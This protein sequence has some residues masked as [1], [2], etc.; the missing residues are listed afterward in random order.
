MVSSS[1]GPRAAG[2]AAAGTE[3]GTAEEKTWEGLWRARLRAVLI[4]LTRA[5][6]RTL[7]CL[8]AVAVVFWI[9]ARRLVLARIGF[10]ESYFLWTGWSLN[11]G[12]VPY[13]DFIEYKPVMIFVLNALGLRLFG[14]DYHHYRYAFAILSGS[15]FLF[16]SLALIR[17]GADALLTFCVVVAMASAL[18]AP[19]LHDLTIN[20]TETVGISFLVLGLA[21]LLWGG[22]HVDLAN[23]LGGAFLALAVMS[24]EPYGFISLTTW[25]ALGFFNRTDSGLPWRRYAVRTCAG[26]AIVALGILGFLLVTGALPYYVTAMRDYFAYTARIGCPKPTTLFDLATVAWRQMTRTLVTPAILGGLLPF[27]IAFAIGSRAR[28]GARIAVVLV[29]LAGVHAVSLGGCYWRHYFIMGL[30]GFLLWGALGAVALGRS[31]SRAPSWLAYATRAVVVVWLVVQVGPR[32][33]TDFETSYSAAR[34]DFMGTP[35]AVINFINQNTA[36]TDYVFS[37]GMPGIFLL[38]NRLRPTRESGFLDEF[39]DSYPG[40]NDVEKLSAV[41]AQLVLRKPKVIYLDRGEA[42]RKRRTRAALIMPFIKEFGYE[43]VM[44][45]VYF[46]RG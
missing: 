25:A 36:P 40:R 26:A 39:I 7:L 22:R 34:V 43:P 33:R 18:S 30:S 17:R 38:T 8:A 42:S 35:P 44:E 14:L 6:K 41:R 12:L 4:L 10:D 29:V 45:N 11:H 9:L 28:W 13:R 46:R 23:T 21:F 24:K 20:D 5:N 16:L 15:S 31:L 37:D 3:E 32:F 2:K 1:E 27:L 19:G